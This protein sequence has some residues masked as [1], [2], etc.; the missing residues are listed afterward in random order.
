MDGGM[1]GGMANQPPLVNGIVVTRPGGTTPLT[2]TVLAGQVIQFTVDALD[3]EG[4]PLT[5]TWSVDGGTLSG[6]TAMQPTWF[7]PVVSV[8]FVSQGLPA[9]PVSV[10]VSDGVNPPVE[11]STD[12]TVRAPQLVDLLAVGAVFGRTTPGS[13]A[14]VSC[15]GSATAPSGGMRLQPSNPTATRMALLA[16]TSRVGCSPMARVQPLQ[17]DNSLLVRKVDQSTPLPFSCGGRMPQAPNP[18]LPASDIV[19]LRSWIAAGA[20]Q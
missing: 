12:V 7:S 13:C 3:P 17:P 9:F 16:N 2:G 19:S 6:S 1:G 4:D 14:S 15:H 5:V 18:M 20:L 8:T 10:S 11:A